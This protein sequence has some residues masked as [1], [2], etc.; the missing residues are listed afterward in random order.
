MSNGVRKC[1]LVRSVF[2][3]TMFIARFW[4]LTAAVGEVLACV[5]EPRNATDRYVVAV[6]K[7]G[8]VIADMLT[9]TKK[10]HGR[11]LARPSEREEGR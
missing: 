6:K 2:V 7:D 9:L 10:G 3:A 5:R 11:M 4:E 1:L 8:R